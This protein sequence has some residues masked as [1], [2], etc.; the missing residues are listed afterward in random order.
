MNNGPQ[1]VPKKLSY[2]CIPCYYHR[3][4]Q[5]LVP[6]N[7]TL[8]SRGQIL[9]SSLNFQDTNITLHSK[10][11]KIASQARHITRWGP[12]LSLSRLISKSTS[13][14]PYFSLDPTMSNASFDHYF[15]VLPSSGTSGVAMVIQYYHVLNIKHGHELYIL[16]IVRHD[17]IR[18]K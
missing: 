5:C 12:T 13:M 3:F 11:H 10:S 14:F 15:C 7:S 8:P 1:Y 18:L 2:T 6:P 9:K 4:Q 16:K 17:K